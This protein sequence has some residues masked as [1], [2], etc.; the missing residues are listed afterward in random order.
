MDNIK[1]IYKAFQAFI[2]QF[3]LP[4]NNDEFGTSEEFYKYFDNPQDSKEL[5]KAIDQLRTGEQ[6][7]V[8]IKFSDGVTKKLSTEF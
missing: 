3:N 5:E 8:D 1:I 6:K 7:E 2:D 4:N